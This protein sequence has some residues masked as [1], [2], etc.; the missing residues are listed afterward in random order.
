MKVILDIKDNQMSSFLELIKGLDYI[1]IIRQIKD[2]KKNKA[3]QE[4]AEAFGDVKLHEDGKKEL[5]PA[6]DLLDE[7]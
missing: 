6:K 5:K 2:E 4:L 1:S 3:I 7:L